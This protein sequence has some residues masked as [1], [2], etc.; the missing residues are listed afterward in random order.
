M[1]RENPFYY[2]LPTH[3]E[4]FLGRWP[5][6]D[7]IVALEAA[8]Q[9][10]RKRLRQALLAELAPLERLPDHGRGEALVVSRDDSAPQP[11]R[12][13]ARLVVEH[14][15]LEAL[16]GLE[17]EHPRSGDHVHAGEDGED[18]DSP[19]VAVA[20]AEVVG[21]GLWRWLEL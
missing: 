4:D 8:H 14:D 15:L 20:A 10:E 12:H 2:N 18:G 16:A 21:A 7:E 13:R 17:V 3:P 9:G 6:V 1:A 5:L 11:E 19:T